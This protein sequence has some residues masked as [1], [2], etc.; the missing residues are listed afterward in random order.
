MIPHLLGGAELADLVRNGWGNA[1]AYVAHRLE[2]RGVPV[3]AVG[4]VGLGAR[5]GERAALAL[6]VEVGLDKGL[7]VLEVAAV[8]GRN[9]SGKAVGHRGMCV[10]KR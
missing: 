10:R 6:G 2:V 7:P 1:E 3:F 5:L 8:H 4:V 9:E